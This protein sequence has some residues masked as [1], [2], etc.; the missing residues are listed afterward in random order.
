MFE[1]YEKLKQAI[2]SKDWQKVFAAYSE[3]TGELIS[4]MAKLCNDLLSEKS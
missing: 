4:E 2:K 3:L 1:H